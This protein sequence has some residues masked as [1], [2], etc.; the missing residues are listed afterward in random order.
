MLRALMNGK[1]MQMRKNLLFYFKIFLNME[2]F[3]REPKVS[4][5]DKLSI[6]MK[7][8]GY[9]IEE[10]EMYRNILNY[11]SI[12]KQKA[13]VAVI[14]ENVV[15][16]IAVAITDYFHRKGAF[17]RIITMVV[18][19]NNRRQGIGRKLIQ[20]AE[21][22]AKDMKCSYIELTSGVYRES[23]GSHDFYK[24]LGYVDLNNSKKY[25]AKEL[26]L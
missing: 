25:F 7:Q 19:Q 3:F 24:S 14:E 12:E 6:L 18:D 23:L 22:Y 21:D 2:I 13:W 15:G 16:C 11:Y 10:N 17:L 1:K 20:I 8:L 4:D 26:N 5:V 9:P